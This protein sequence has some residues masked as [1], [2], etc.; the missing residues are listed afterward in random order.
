[1]PVDPSLVYSRSAY[2]TF[3]WW[4]TEG[5]GSAAD[6]GGGTLLFSGGYKLTGSHIRFVTSKNVKAINSAEKV[7]DIVKPLDHFSTDE[8]DITR[9]TSDSL[10][11][12]LIRNDSK[13]KFE[14]NSVIHTD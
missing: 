2:P 11:M 4:I 9:L 10:H 14:C 5:E 13:F 8:G 3:Q 12:S 1:M 7:F 6:N